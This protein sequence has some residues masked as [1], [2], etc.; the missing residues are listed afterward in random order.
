MKGEKEKKP[1]ISL[2]ISKIFATTFDHWLDLA[3]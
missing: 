2:N 3:N 1:G